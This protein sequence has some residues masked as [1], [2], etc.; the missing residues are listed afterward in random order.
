M[1]YC[2]E[3]Q[4]TYEGASQRFCLNDG[5]RLVRALP[6][7][8]SS[9][10]TNGVFK[11]ILDRKVET[12][13]DKFV[14]APRFSRARIRR[15]ADSDFLP[16]FEAEIFEVNP[17]SELKTESIESAFEAVPLPESIVESDFETIAE[18]EFAPANDAEII[19]TPPA[20]EI[21]AQSE[22]EIEIQPEAETEIEVAP[23]IEPQIETEIEAAPPIEIQS[24]AET[25]FEVQPET[26][27][28]I[29]PEIE[30]EIEIQT[31][32]EEKES[33]N[34]A[35]PHFIAP[36]EIP[37]GEALL[38]DGITNPAGRRSLTWKNPSALVEQ[39]IK[40][41]YLIVE[42]TGKDENSIAYL[43]EDKIV[44]H[45]KI[46]VRVLMN[47]DANDSFARKIYAE[48][49][50]S[51]SRINHPNI[52]NLI[53]SGELP[54][55]KPFI[56]SEFVEGKSV[57][58]LLQSSE[59]FDVERVARV[60]RQASCA[61]SEAHQNGILHRNLK[62]ENLV[63]TI[64]EKDSE[65]VKLTGFGA[66]K[67]KLNESN[68]PYKSPEQIEGKLANVTSDEY[69]LAIIAYRMLSGKMPFKPARSIAKSLKARREN[70]KIK[71]GKTQTDLPAATEKIFERALAFEVAE[72]YPKARDFGEAFYEAVFADANLKTRETR[73]IETIE[74]PLSVSLSDSE[75]QNESARE[76]ENH[77]ATKT[78]E[79]KAAATTAGETKSNRAL[80]AVFGAAVLLLGIWIVWSLLPNRANEKPI[81]QNPPTNANIVNQ[82][83]TNAPQ[84]NA[85]N[86]PANQTAETAPRSIVQPPNTN[87][88]RNDRENLK[89]EALKNYLGFSLYYPKD[90]KV[91]QASG[92]SADARGTFFDISKNAPSGTPIEQFIVSYYDSNG[93]FQTDTENFAKQ[94]IETNRTLS[95]IIPNYVV[96]SKG[97]KTIN[98]GRQAYELKFQGTGMTPAGE[99]LTL[100]GNRLFVPA[101]I[102]GVKNG[103]M[104]TMLATS[105][106]E[107]VK[108]AADVG[109]KGDLP[110]ILSTFEPNQNF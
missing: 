1:F 95:K 41:R 92:G 93:T 47:E 34:E 96:V 72:R 18:T 101:A 39:T 29:Q 14:D 107:D 27:I 26:E 86:L 19:E 76:D 3:C 33:S 87:Y 44:P 12:E 84:I 15:F 23:E 53:D 91:N 71:F 40:G 69:A 16:P 80:F 38:G 43:A 62:P 109:A 58:E 13:I 8:A 5:R 21:E 59:N 61:L 22:P 57:E 2:P 10:Q 75:S 11:N 4:K 45:K 48:E 36:R 98:D 66:A 51:L 20:T 6:D 24:E 17:S 52:A 77:A 31:E 82:T 9:A 28:E 100:W 70:L 110:K 74:T 32:I 90:W 108:N 94:V 106:S 88:F 102:S 35:A 89:D 46:V 73:E 25:K 37:T 85:N 65:Q 30:A 78:V 64:N 79:G 83:A 105:L 60:V 68:L 56:V 67:E 104:I 7:D 50:V 54:E 42:Q 55:G 49:R 97:E 81:V 63:L 103:Y 99:K